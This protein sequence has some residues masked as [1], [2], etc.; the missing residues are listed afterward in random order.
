MKTQNGSFA[1]RIRGSILVVT[2]AATMAL[3]WGLHAGAT[4]S[5]QAGSTEQTHNEISQMASYTK[6]GRYEDAIQLGLELLK[7]DPTDEVVHQQIA[8]VYL[9]RAQKDRDK[10]EEWVTE[11]VAYLEKSLSLNSKDKDT[12][13]VHLFQDARAFEAA[14]DLSGDK[15]CAYYDKARKLLEDRASRLL[16]DQVTLAGKTFPMEPLRNENDRVLAGIEDK[17]TKAG[18]K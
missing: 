4:N 18:C 2:F 17:V 9:I 12:A 14:G 8:D 10:R 16:G 3:A 7:S 5:K 15:K 13:G 1:R 11:A 6:Q